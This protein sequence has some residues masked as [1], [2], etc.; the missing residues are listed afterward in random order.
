M[1]VATSSLSLSLS[2][3]RQRNKVV[4]LMISGS[5]LA[6]W[7]L[8]GSPGATSDVA[9]ELAYAVYGAI[10]LPM[11]ARPPKVLRGTAARG[12]V[13]QLSRLPKCAR[14]LWEAGT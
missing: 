3:Q 2:Q 8:G 7:W 9:S 12:V 13:A 5:R 11:N 10:G 4:V 14:K 1:V 6:A